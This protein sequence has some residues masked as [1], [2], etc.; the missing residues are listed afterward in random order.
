[1][2][3][4]NSSLSLSYL[5]FATSKFST[6]YSIS[7]Y[8]L[9]ISSNNSSWLFETLFSYISL[10]YYDSNTR[11]IFHTYFKCYYLEEL[12][13]PYLHFLVFMCVNTYECVLLK[14]N[15]ILHIGQC[16]TLP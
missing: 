10:S 8:L 7:F 1:M 3:P 16:F 11:L 4:L 9:I 14:L 15:Y 12:D 2:S 13:I 6:L 5:S